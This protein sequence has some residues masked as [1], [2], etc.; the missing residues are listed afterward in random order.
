MTLS[1]VRLVFRCFCLTALI[2]FTA[3]AAKAQQGRPPQPSDDVLRIN[4]DLVQTAITVVDKKGN[5]VDGLDRAQFE[6]RVDGQ[7][8]PISFF[9]RVTAG[10]EREAQLTA[11]NDGSVAAPTTRNATV[12]GRTIV[13]FIDDMHLSADSLHRTREMLRKFLVSEMTSRDSVAIVSAS[14]QLGFLQQFTN[15][16]VVLSAAIDRLTLR[17]YEVRG[18]GTG[19]TR[20]REFDAL[21]ID[22]G[23]RANNEVLS[24]YIGECIK[25]SGYPSTVTVMKKA[26]AATCE[27]QV[28]N[29]ARAILMQAGT[30]TQNM[31]ASLE[32]L[33]RSSARVPGRKLA[34]FISDGF[35]LDAGPHGP[36]LRGKLESII[37]AAQ[38]AGVVVYTI[39]SRGLTNDNVDVRQGS[40]RLD[41][42]APVGE[43][44]AFQDAMHALAG[45]TG[46]RALRN[47]N[48]FDRWVEKV[49]DETSNYYLLAWRPDKEEERTFKFRKV[50]VTIAGHPE[51]TVRAPRGYVPGPAA[52]APTDTVSATIKASTNQT[53]NGPEADLRDALGDYYPNNSLPTRLSLTYINTPKN[54]NV[55]TSSM[56]V[57]SGSLYYGND[58]SQPAT[59]RVAGV[60]LN[61]QGKIASS[62]RNQLNVKPVA[63]G[64]KDASGIFYNEHT[65]MAPGIYQV[66]VAARDE[67]SGRVGSALQWVVIPDLSTHKLTLSSLMLGGQ[68]LETGSRKEG[69]AQVQ[70]SVDHRFPR[71]AV[72]EVWLFIYNAKRDASGAPSLTVQTVVERD[73]RT[74]LSA[75]QRRLS[76]GAPDP[77]RI[78]LGEKLA[79][80]S[81]APGRYDLRVIITDTIAGTSVTQSTDFE[82]Q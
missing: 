29:S 41:V 63:A 49:L 22:S 82:V 77:E 67:K 66:R 47:Q 6:L 10:S 34:F 68:L 26:V 54:E 4:A 12:R 2:V 36:G 72:L 79:L 1:K 13:F 28:R 42:G 7:P 45:D 64:R 43:V 57:A 62:F 8:R 75:P 39:D 37:D 60:I 74:V 23:S 11:K 25:Q 78:G 33:M 20:M 3:G 50:R 44:A 59:I 35:L 53:A 48:Y 80:K 27:T 17:Q 16:K 76:N 56:Q 55:L 30:L 71:T 24:Y 18:Y 81:L 40:A 65:P 52:A 61:D 19:S 46:G 69:D 14:G 15:N 9:E 70:F 5:F 73:G 31:Y 51:L 58:G 32:S 38:R 21:V